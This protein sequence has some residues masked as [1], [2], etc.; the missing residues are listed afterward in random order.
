M[1][2]SAGSDDLLGGAAKSAAKTPAKKAAAKTPAKVPA[3][4]AAVKTPPA[5]KAAAKV[6]AKKVVAKKAASGNGATRVSTARGGGKFYFE[7]SA[8]EALSK[9]IAKIGK[10]MTTKELAEKFEAPTWQVRLAGKDAVDLKL[11]KLGPKTGTT[12][13]FVPK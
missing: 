8:R 12:V 4:K 6:P 11:I 3:K 1:L 5:K 13:T 9:R 10:A 7:P 2:G